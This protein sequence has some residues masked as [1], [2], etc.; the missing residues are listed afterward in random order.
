MENN[1]NE[2]V[3]SIKL[4]DFIQNSIEK[5]NNIEFYSLEIPYST[6]S[7]YFDVSGSKGLIFTF[8]IGSKPILNYKE[9]YFYK[10]LDDGNSIIKIDK[11]MIEK[12]GEE[13]KGMKFI[14][15]MFAT[16]LNDGIGQ[17]NFRARADNQYYKEYIYTDTNTETIC[18]TNN[19]NEDCIF[20]I[21]VVNNKI[22]FENKQNL[23]LY[24]FSS[25]NSENLILSFSKVN[26]N[27]TEEIHFEYSTESQFIKNML[28]IP[29]DVLKTLKKGEDILIKVGVPEKGIITLLST[30]K[31]NLKE[32]FIHFKSRT[33]YDVEPNK[34]LLLN[35]PSGHRNLVHI[36]IID[37][38]GKIGF[39]NDDENMQIINGKYSAFYLQSEENNN[40]LK[41]KVKTEKLYL[42]FYIYLKI[43]TNKRNINQ[44]SIGTSAK[45][46]TKKGFPI[47]FY[48]LIPEKVEKDFNIN[49]RF[50]NIK[51]FNDDFN[52][53][54]TE[55]KTSKFKIKVFVVEEKII[56]K[57]KNDENI[58]YSGNEMNTFEG[59]YEAGFGISKIILKKD[60]LKSNA[61]NYI[62][63][64][65]DA[66]ASNIKRFSDINAELNVLEVNNINYYAP[67]NVYLNGNLDHQNNKGEFKIVKKNEKD[68]KIRVELSSSEDVSFSIALFNISQVY[69][70]L[71]EDINYEVSKGLGKK[72]IDINVEEI[73]N[74][75]LFTIYH[76]NLPENHN[77]Y[78]SFKYKSSDN[79]KNYDVLDNKEGLI[80]NEW[81]KDKNKLI[82][83]FKFPSI[84]DK[85]TS[86]KVNAKYY[87]KIY[88][89][90]QNEIIIN[91]TISVVDNILPIV[92]Y[93]YNFEVLKDYYE[94]ELEIENFKNG[95]NYYATLTAIVVDDDEFVAYKSFSFK[96]I[97]KEK[98][99]KK[100]SKF[101]IIFIII[102]VVLIIVGVFIC[103]YFKKIKNKSSNSNS[104][105]SIN[106]LSNI[107]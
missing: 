90:D 63:I 16:S 7:I 41:I 53:E 31:T 40:D 79:F 71:S 10:E 74:P 105:D 17:F 22:F 45:F 19:N 3:V 62:Y 29:N 56:E 96:E 36:N 86:N 88:K 82:L 87:L 106:E 14:I 77:I 51:E 64:I 47:E 50:N 15:G 57:I 58:I 73:N 5:I 30:F 24:A 32:S 39:E 28:T 94:K 21:P 9:N 95:D 70:F 52:K 91:N 98:E 61:K 65:I 25:A 67:N 97:E 76:E 44:I 20:L 4:N 38:E 46:S 69:K 59:K 83:N 60:S 35:V 101:W 55:I 100:S 23:F 66:D 107:N 37:G 27:K 1:Y 75:L 54:I 13:L 12:V 26:L 68:K 81:E 102:F 93:E 99:K 103:I 34:E 33:V 85:E 8:N 92:S 84:I 72:Y 78:Y 6:N 104:E 2:N 48:Y 49:F 42:K 89:H 43:G 11:N 18:N 80:E